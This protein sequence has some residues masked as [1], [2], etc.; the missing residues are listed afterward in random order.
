MYHWKHP[1]VISREAFKELA[2]FTKILL[3]VTKVSIVGGL[4]E[5]KSDTVVDEDIICFNGEEP[6]DGETFYFPRISNDLIGAVPSALGQYF[7]VCDTYGQPYDE[8]VLAVLKGAKYLEIID[9]WYCEDYKE[10]HEE[11]EHLFEAVKNY[12]R[13]KQKQKE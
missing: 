6:E 7:R 12:Y 13:I 4:G 10:D 8:V 1:R 5:S 9:E 3:D 11:G 2:E